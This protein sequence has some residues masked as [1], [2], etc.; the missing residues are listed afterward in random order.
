MY[1]ERHE[2]GKTCTGKERAKED[3][4]PEC[5]ENG[6]MTWIGVGATICGWVAMGPG[7]KRAAIG[8]ICNGRVTA[9]LAPEAVPGVGPALELPRMA[10]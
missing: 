4:A 9:E 8:D 2:L 6:A 1:W 7:A 5:P 10:V 3:S